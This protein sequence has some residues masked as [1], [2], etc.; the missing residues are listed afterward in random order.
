MN[1]KFWC[2][3]IPLKKAKA[4]A[5]TSLVEIFSY[6]TGTAQ[7][8]FKGGLFLKSVITLCCQIDVANNREQQVYKALERYQ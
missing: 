3:E 2:A 8:D 4:E 5:S 7:V 1:E 6:P